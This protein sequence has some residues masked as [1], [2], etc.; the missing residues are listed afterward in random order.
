MVKTEKLLLHWWPTVL[1]LKKTIAVLPKC[2]LEEVVSMTQYLKAYYP[3]LDLSLMKYIFKS[4][5]ISFII[6]LYILLYALILPF[7]CF[8]LLY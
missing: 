6:N 8:L 4:E 3:C 5:Q 7:F 1:R 2:L